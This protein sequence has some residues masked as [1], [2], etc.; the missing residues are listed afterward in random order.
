M[1]TSF[2]ETSNHLTSI[3][4]KPLGFKF[5]I[6][7]FKKVLNRI[8]LRCDQ[9]CVSRTIIQQ[10][11]SGSNLNLGQ[12]SIIELNDPR[13]VGGDSLC[14][15]IQNKGSLSG[16]INLN[17]NQGIV[18]KFLFLFNMFYNS[19]IFFLQNI[20]GKE[21]RIKSQSLKKSS[22]TVNLVSLNSSIKTNEEANEQTT[23]F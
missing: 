9:T 20:I 8:R 18:I 1:T 5:F 11:Y 2:S 19:L 12:S 17:L 4:G 10:Q 15:F 22:N 14:S 13:C 7:C 3:I 16:S 21:A 6:D 23:K